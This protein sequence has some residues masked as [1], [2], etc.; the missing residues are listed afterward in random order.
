MTF[1]SRQSAS[2]PTSP[3]PMKTPNAVPTE[4]KP[5]PPNTANAQGQ[6]ESMNFEI[7]KD[8]LKYD[9]VMNRQRSVVYE[10]RKRVLTGQDVHDELV[11]MIDDTVGDYVRAATS[12]GFAEDWDLEQLLVDLKQLYPVGVT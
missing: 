9:D 7:R 2:R 8:V 10:E 1:R 11:T 6:V 5:T 4:N 3:T 12:E